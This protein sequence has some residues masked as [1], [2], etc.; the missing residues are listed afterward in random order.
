MVGCLSRCARVPQRGTKETFFDFKSKL[1]VPQ[2]W[3]RPVRG[4]VG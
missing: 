2:K 4:G 1:R 3:T